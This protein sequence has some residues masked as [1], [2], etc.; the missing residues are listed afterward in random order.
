MRIISRERSIWIGIW[1]DHPVSGSS[2]EDYFKIGRRRP[3]LSKK[4]KKLFMNLYCLYRSGIQWNRISQATFY[5]PG[6]EDSVLRGEVN[7][8]PSMKGM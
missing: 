6:V 4:K 5:F 7:P 1:L 3:A 2:A 8:G